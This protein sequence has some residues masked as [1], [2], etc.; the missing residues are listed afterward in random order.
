MPVRKRD[1]VNNDVEEDVEDLILN[2]LSI[3][4]FSDCLGKYQ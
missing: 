1:N 2:F 3:H 4:R